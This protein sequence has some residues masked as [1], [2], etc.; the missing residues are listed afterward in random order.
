M[1]GYN[2][3]RWG[4][5]AT[6][7]GCASLVLSVDHIMHGFSGVMRKQN[8]SRPSDDN[9]LSIPWHAWRWIRSGESEPWAELELRL[10]LRAN[11]GTAWLRYD[12]EHATRPSGP[13]H[14][15]L[16][17]ATTP[18]RFGGQRWWWICP[19][20]GARVSKLYLP[21]GGHRFLSRGRGAYCLAYASQRQGATGRMHERSRKLYARLG[22]D[23][24]G[25]L[26]G[27]P[28]K[29][30]GMHWRT[31]ESICDRLQMESDGLDMGLVRVFE[32]LMRREGRPAVKR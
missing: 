18:C 25:L 30:K 27:W 6:V 3:G 1:G 15:S 2:S 4:G 20:T 16:S 9:P 21:N 13:Q 29:P 5:Q 26:G 12:F 8:R 28:P 31:Y 10:E 7:E 22:A 17:M 32:R 14:Y 23:Y 19:A 24:S 11:D